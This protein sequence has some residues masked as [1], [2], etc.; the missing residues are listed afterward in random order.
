MS[1]ELN[2]I[3]H[4]DIDVRRLS[5]MLR[6]HMIVHN[7][8]YR[9]GVLLS[10]Y[11]AEQGRRLRIILHHS[12]RNVSI[13]DDDIRHHV[14]Q[15][16]VTAFQSHQLNRFIRRPISGMVPARTSATLSAS[17]TVQDTG[18]QCSICFE[19][20]MSDQLHCLPC[21]HMFHESCIRRWFVQ[22]VS[23]PVCRLQ[24]T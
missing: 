1:T 2:C 5:S 10:P 19:T 3:V 15:T 7:P 12:S 14:L 4:Q 16:T 22:A 11:I 23:C 6:E 20:I 18:K 17:A 24:L 13:V 8:P 9:L 21:A